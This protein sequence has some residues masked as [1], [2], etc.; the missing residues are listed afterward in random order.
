MNE[1]N[2]CPMCGTAVPK[3]EGRLYQYDNGT[4]VFEYV[5][6]NCVNLHDKL[7]NQGGVR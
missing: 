3:R 7:A 4:I 6:P 2:N 1:L 5:C